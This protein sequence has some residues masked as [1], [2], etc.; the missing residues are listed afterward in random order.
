MARTIRDFQNFTPQGLKPLYEKL[1]AYVRNK[2]ATQYPGKVGTFWLRLTFILGISQNKYFDHISVNDPGLQI[3]CN[4]NPGL[5]QQYWWTIL[6][7]KIDRYF[8]L[9][10]R[11]RDL[12]IDFHRF[13]LAVLCPHICSE[14]C[15]FS[16]LKKKNWHVSN[17]QK[18]P[19]VSF[20]R[21]AQ[22]WS[23]IGDIL[24]PY[25]GKPNLNVTGAMLS[26]VR[27]F[28]YC[29]NENLSFPTEPGAILIA[30]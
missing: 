3:P 8:D 12:S 19:I 2:L 5:C 22:Q 27:I 24:K 30:R 29:Q 13:N 1:H 17:L 18:K 10:F 9:R 25:P 21:W 23:N 16:Y 11:Y 7:M 15:E 28:I 20:C 4:G 14:T 26:Q 6:W